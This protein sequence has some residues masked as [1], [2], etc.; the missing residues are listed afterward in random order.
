MQTELKAV[1]EK[2]VR[3]DRSGELGARTA[4]ELQLKMA[5]DRID[6]ALRT[7]VK[8]RH[9]LRLLT[10]PAF[11]RWLGEMVDAET[12]TASWHRGTAGELLR[13]SSE[14]VEMV[15]EEEE[16]GSPAAYLL[17]LASHLASCGSRRID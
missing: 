12:K 4:K 3:Q 1:V 16:E 2:A 8:T 10:A 11:R 14:Q 13:R 15:G 6:W 17:E 7:P 5:L 9:H